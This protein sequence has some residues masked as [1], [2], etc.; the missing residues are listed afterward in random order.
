MTS[1]IT[2]ALDGYWF[3]LG[4]CIYSLETRKLIRRCEGVD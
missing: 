4:I 2:Q 3:K 1:D